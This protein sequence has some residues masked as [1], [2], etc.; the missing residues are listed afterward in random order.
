[1]TPLP[2]IT[3]SP[4][5]RTIHIAPSTNNAASY[6]CTVSIMLW[7]CPEH[8]Y[9]T[10]VHARGEYVH[11]RAY[12]AQHDH[13]KHFML[14]MAQG[15][16]QLLAI[17]GRGM[18]RLMLHTCVAP[19]VR[20]IGENAQDYWICGAVR[21]RTGGLDSMSPALPGP[22]RCT[23]LQEGCTPVHTAAGS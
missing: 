22:C 15:P 13:G 17:T 14:G 20:K 3:G 21:P 1:M 10:I 5:E 11:Y 19:S 6:P 2:H 7:C 8:F 12:L 9:H 4:S 16:W 18:I 23:S